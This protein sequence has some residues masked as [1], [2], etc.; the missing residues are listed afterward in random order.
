M[1]RTLRWMF[2]MVIVALVLPSVPAAGQPRGYQS[3][4]SGWDFDFDGIAGESTGA[5][6]AICDGAGGT[7]EDIDGNGV[8]DRQVYVDL[9]SGSDTLSCGA[10]GSPCRTLQYAMS[11]SNTSFADRIQAPGA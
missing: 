5:D 9:T 11:G 7:N 10:P 4:A 2:S 1:T 3:R 8:V 6:V